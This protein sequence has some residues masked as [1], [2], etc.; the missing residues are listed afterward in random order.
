MSKSGSHFSFLEVEIGIVERRYSESNADVVLD[1]VSVV[2]AYV[3]VLVPDE[4]LDIENSLTICCALE[5]TVRS[6][7][8][9]VELRNV[10]TTSTLSNPAP[11]SPALVFP[12]N[13]RRLT[14][15]YEHL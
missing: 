7:G 2:W 9:I 6:A 10:R 3:A 5:R 13:S 12:N 15:V 1:F 14:K 4:R 11:S 8:D